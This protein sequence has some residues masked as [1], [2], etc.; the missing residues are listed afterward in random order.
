MDMKCWFFKRKRLGRFGISKS[1]MRKIIL[2]LVLFSVF[3]CQR[4]ES[5]IES[6]NIEQKIKSADCE[7]DFDVFFQEFAKDSV[8]QKII[9]DFL[10]VQLITV[11][12]LMMN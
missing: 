5:T 10:Y 3:S 8:F 7:T 6:S 1:S 4:K 11:E 9:S 12:M 2:I